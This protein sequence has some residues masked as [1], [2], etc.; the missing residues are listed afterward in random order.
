MSDGTSTVVDFPFTVN[1]TAIQDSS[2]GT[3]VE[4]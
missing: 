3:E 2:I 1:V 4:Q